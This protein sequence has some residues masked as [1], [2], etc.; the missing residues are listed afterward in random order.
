MLLTM[1]TLLLDEIFYH[2]YRSWQDRMWLITW[3]ILEN[4][5]YRQLTVFWR[6]RGLLKF[7][8][9]QKSWGTIEQR[10]LALSP[11]GGYLSKNHC[12]PLDT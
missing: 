12:N 9:H 6:L 10:G 4:F 2:R 8:R 3:T 5:G 7:L 11:D 1:L